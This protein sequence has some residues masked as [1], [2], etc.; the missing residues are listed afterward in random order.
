M[1]SLQGV[2]RTWMEWVFEHG[3]AT[4]ELVVE[5]DL[6]IQP[7]LAGFDEAAFNELIDR[8]ATANAWGHYDRIRIIPTGA[9]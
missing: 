7:G 3:T 5:T 6:Q 2:T 8:V 1:I 4:A 9:R